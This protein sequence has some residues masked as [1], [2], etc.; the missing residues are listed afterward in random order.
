MDE[1]AIK[2]VAEQRHRLLVAP[3]LFLLLQNIA[4][5]CVE[6]RLRIGLGDGIEQ[7]QQFEAHLSATEG[8]GLDDDDVRGSLPKGIEQQVTTPRQKRFVDGFAGLIGKARKTGTAGDDRRQRH[9]CYILARKAV[10]RNAA[11]DDSH[12]AAIPSHRAGDTAGPRQM[13]DAKQMLDVKEDTRR[14]GMRGHHADFRH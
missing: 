7:R 3:G 9:G 2:V 10:D 8:E 11:G 14:R 5:R 4:H 1:N 13:A 6:P 12:P